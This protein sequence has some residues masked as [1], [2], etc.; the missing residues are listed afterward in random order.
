MWL[1]NIPKGPCAK[2]FVENG[3][4]TVSMTF[5]K[6]I[7]TYKYH[8][9]SSHHEGTQDDWKLSEGYKTTSIF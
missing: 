5:K 4:V 7:L 3:K 2:F 1:A 6:K 8:F 9:N